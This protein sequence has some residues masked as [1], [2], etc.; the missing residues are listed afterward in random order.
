MQMGVRNIYG[1]DSLS[2]HK[3]T[4]D[5]NCHKKKCGHSNRLRP[6]KKIKYIIAD[7]VVS[8]LRLILDLVNYLTIECFWN[9]FC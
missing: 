8:S 6:K 9:S 7:I 2:M 4:L 5:V 1:F 3:D